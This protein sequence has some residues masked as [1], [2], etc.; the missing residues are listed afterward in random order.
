[1]STRWKLVVSFRFRVF[2]LPGHT[3]DKRLDEL[4][5][6]CGGHAKYSSSS[7]QPRQVV[8]DLGN[9]APE[10]RQFTQFRMNAISP[11]S[12]LMAFLPSPCH[13]T[14]LLF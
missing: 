14:A 6:R 11:Y 12:P 13:S 5:S 2:Y 4:H 1:V 9:S 3:L 7:E 8:H 10:E